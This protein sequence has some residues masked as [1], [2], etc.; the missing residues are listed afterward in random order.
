M[1]ASPTATLSIGMSSN[2]SPV[3]RCAT[4][5]A[6]SIRDFRSRSARPTAKSSSTVP[7]AYMMATTTPASVWPSASAAAIDTNATAS[8]PILPART[9]RAI[10]IARPATTG[11]VPAAHI[12]RASPL[13]PVKAATSPVASAANAMMIRAR[14]SGPLIEHRCHAICRF[15]HLGADLHFREHERSVATK[16]ETAPPAAEIRR[17][18]RE[19][20]S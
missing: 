4:R 8:T 9:S 5:G 18:P 17:A 14:R 20:L 10:E 7:P 19:Q 2:N 1:I 12:H 6:R 3:L 15:N 11:I 16:V 13:C